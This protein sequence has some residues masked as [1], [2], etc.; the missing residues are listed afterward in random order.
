MNES[1][2]INVK[3]ISGLFIIKEFEG[4]I[5]Y[6]TNSSTEEIGSAKGFFNS[7]ENES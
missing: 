1:Y 5:D 7:V 4:E 6:G 3:R 2:T